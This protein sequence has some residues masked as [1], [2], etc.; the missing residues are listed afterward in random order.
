MA[1]LYKTL[2]LELARS[3]EAGVYKPGDRFPGIRHTST[4]KSVSPSTA[5]AA[6]RQ[7]ELDGYLEARSRS[8]FYVLPRQQNHIEEPEQ[9]RVTRHR[10]RLVENQELV[11][12]V[13]EQVNAPRVTRFGAAVVDSQFLPTRSLE[14]ALKAVAREQRSQISNYAHPKGEAILRHQIAKHM[15]NIGCPTDPDDIII[16]NGCQE[17]VYI[18]LKSLTSPGDVVVLESPTFHGHLQVAESLG[19]KVLEIPTHPRTGISL[20]ALELALEQWPI[21]A[22]LLI[23]NF[24]NPLGSC[25][26]DDHK[27]ALVEL[28]RRYQ[29]A[30]IEDDIYGDLPF[31]QKRPSVLKSLDQEDNILHCSSFSKTLAPGLR[32]GWIIPGRYYRQVYLQKFITSVSTAG[33]GQLAIA[34]LME[35]GHYARHLQFMRTELAQSTHRIREAISQSFPEDTR[36][37]NPDGGYVLWVE[38]PKS[39][40]TVKLLPLA[41]EQK[42]SIAPGPIFSASGKYR[43]FMRISCGVVWNRQ[44]R[45]AIE[46]LAELA[47]I[48][49]KL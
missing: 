11:L 31:N 43:N 12:S 3:I 49:G 32:V 26:P 6:Y 29:V 47:R 44:T 35:S 42:I 27:Q 23:P 28:T 38:L 39:V 36:I 16:T 34:R 10:P 20:D 17:A 22:C 45:D 48:T 40:D 15:Y 37:T 30:I 24:N 25:M 2:A 19:L 9:S 14:K 5:V 46:K 4:S 33:I 7:L 21:K 13:A 8:G 18:A 41:A 1:N